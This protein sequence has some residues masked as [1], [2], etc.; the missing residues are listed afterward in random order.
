MVNY[1][2]KNEIQ[3]N[4]FVDFFDKNENVMEISSKKVI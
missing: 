1:L 3:F 2:T 4:D